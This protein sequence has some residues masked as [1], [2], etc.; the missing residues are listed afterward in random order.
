MAYGVPPPLRTSP[1]TCGSIAHPV[2]GKTA[3]VASLDISGHFRLQQ[4]CMSKQ[5]NFV[6]EIQLTQQGVLC[7]LL[8]PNVR[9]HQCSQ[10]RPGPGDYNVYLVSWSSS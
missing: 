10:R 3:C 2:I 7:R 8:K 5:L 6:C 9:G 1:D 4:T